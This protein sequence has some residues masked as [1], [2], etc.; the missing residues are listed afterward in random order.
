MNDHDLHHLL[1]AWMDLGP[2]VAPVRVAD[3]A[4]LEARSTRQVVTLAGWTPPRLPFLNMATLQ[5]ALATV[6][7]VAV[8]LLGYRYLA[9]SS[10]GGPGIEDP[11]PSPTASSSTRPIPLTFSAG[12]L[13]PGR[14]TLAGSFPV[15]L[16]L[17]LPAGWSSCSIGV[18]E[19]GVCRSPAQDEFA[20]GINFLFVE[21]VVADP[22]NGSDLQDPPVGPTVEDLVT[23][24][25]SLEGFEATAAE[26]ATVDG[27]PAKR[28]TVTAPD[29]SGCDLS[30]W[31]T[32][33]RTN[34][35]GRSEINDLHIVDVD[36]VRI[37]ISAAYF[38][39]LVTPEDLAATEEVLASIQIEP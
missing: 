5:V 31:A 36:G 28:L 29:E 11:L 6:L 35:V 12:N 10:V 26:D 1:D 23:A 37:L 18:L 15:E 14:Y 30:T 25:S 20:I 39:E 2:E 33:D 22:C 24:V 7:I 8:T 16:T 32:P 9:G 38:P 21:N 17:D 3:A 34:G 27:F 13:A 4:R 19:Q